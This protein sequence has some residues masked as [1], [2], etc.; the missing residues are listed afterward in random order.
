MRLRLFISAGILAIALVALL[1]TNFIRSSRVSA[2]KATSQVPT[3]IK[4]IPYGPT[5][6]EL[7]ATKSAATRHPDV[8]KFLQGTRNRLISF[9]LIEPDNK[10]QERLPATLFRVQFYDYTNNR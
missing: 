1:A 2:T 10:G 8:V 6:A 3:Q 9:Q 7:D 5:Q 4:V